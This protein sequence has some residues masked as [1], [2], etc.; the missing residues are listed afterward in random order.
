MEVCT[1]TS[2]SVRLAV[3]MSLYRDDNS[4]VTAGIRSAVWA[5]IIHGSSSC[6]GSRVS[7]RMGHARPGNE[8]GE[9][10]A[11]RPCCPETAAIAR[12]I[13]RADAVNV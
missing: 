5:D 1:V 4:A 12:A 6:R 2:P 13:A 7:C 9:R 8:A 11:A 3:A 10:G